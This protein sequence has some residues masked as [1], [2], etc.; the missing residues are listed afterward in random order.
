MCLVKRVRDLP[1]IIYNKHPGHYVVCVVHENESEN[2]VSFNTNSSQGL[3]V[4]DDG[5][6]ILEQHV[7]CKIKLWYVIIFMII[8]LLAGCIS[9]NTS[10]TLVCIQKCQYLCHYAIIF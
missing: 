3:T 6:D 8:V 7:V 2:L 4:W 5:M 10:E 9:S 1:N